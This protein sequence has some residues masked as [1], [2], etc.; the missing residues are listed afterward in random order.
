MIMKDGELQLCMDEP[1]FAIL[2]PKGRRRGVLAMLLYT[3]AAMG[4]QLA[5]HKGERR[6]QICWIGVQLEIAVNQ[7]M[8][9]LTVPGKVVKELLAKMKE[10]KGKGVI[11]FRGPWTAGIIPR[12]RWLVSILYAVVASVEA[13]EKAGLEASRAASRTDTRPKL[14]LVP[15]KWS[16]L[17]PGYSLS[18]SNHISGWFD[19]SR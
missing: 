1:L 5:F 4:V 12:M 18:W 16:C 8:L 13:D 17:V 6:L 19:R 7:A 15:A 9:L 11:A 10:W 2:G 3:A 14:G